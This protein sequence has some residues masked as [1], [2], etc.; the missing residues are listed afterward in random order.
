MS[1]E[2]LQVMNAS[3]KAPLRLPKLA[4]IIQIQAPEQFQV[5][6]EGRRSWLVPAMST[7]SVAAPSSEE[8]E[9]FLRQL[10]AEL[11]GELDETSD[12]PDA[13]ETANRNDALAQTL[14]EQANRVKPASGALSDEGRTAPAI[15]S[16]SAPEPVKPSQ[17]ELSLEEQASRVIP[18]RKKFR[19]PSANHVPIGGRAHGLSVALK[20][21]RKPSA[22]ASTSA[23]EPAKPPARK[24]KRPTRA[25]K[26]RD[27]AA[28]EEEGEISKSAI[29]SLVATAPLA[30]TI[31]RANDTCPPHPGFL[32]GMCI[33]C[34]QL[35]T[36]ESREQLKAE[37]QPL[38][39]KHLHK[40][41][42][43]NKEYV[44]ELK[45]S[46]NARLIAQKKLSLV[47][48]LDHTL[49]NSS[50][51][52]DIMMCDLKTINAVVAREHDK[53]GHEGPAGKV[54]D[55]RPETKTGRSLFLL[56]HIQMW[57]KLRPY[58]RELLCE[59]SKLYDMH[60]YTMGER[61]YAEEM[62]KLLDPDKSLFGDNI[63]SKND[64][65]KS[66]TKDLDVLIG[67]ER[68]V[69]ILDDSPRVW[70][71]CRANVLEVERYHFFPSSLR[72]FNIR[73]KC[74][75]DRKNDES[76]DMGPL[77]SV[78]S[79][80]R[81]IHKEYFASGHP[82]HMDVREILRR[83]KK[84]VLLG[85]KICFSRVFPQ[86]ETNPENHPLWRLAEEFGAE[87]TRTLDD[88]V[89]HLVTTSEGTEKAMRASEMGKHVVRPEWVYHSAWGFKRSPEKRHSGGKIDGG[90][91]GGGGGAAKEI[92]GPGTKVEEAREEGEI[93]EVAPQADG[94][95]GGER[96]EDGG[97]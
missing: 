83:R 97:G 17:E 74:L 88:A 10:E 25:R 39:L 35:Q 11:E 9:W 73:G 94:G 36:Q 37:G 29:P 45:A 89:T 44:R 56:E 49:L 41:L 63:V 68:T 40:D 13:A 77:A 64:S 42:E 67:N 15:A 16:T 62:A 18:T 85:C 78:L 14:E 50:Q 84:R 48:D 8:D 87:C 54:A 52:K 91:G 38:S 1:G 19:I 46:E 60:I 33:R 71:K 22:I 47:F 7:S 58:Y 86:G 96:E 70:K 5:E 26:K 82:E 53:V 79:V 65:T 43:M 81:E 31:P 21:M 75:L 76:S 61:G 4:S 55:L 59:C 72:H 66:D 24:F 23:P 69:L 90:G 3:S 32:R 12:L 92:G 34:G 30:G 2:T 6:E 20:E 93:V 95:R 28:V 57:T 80:L 27:R 51:L